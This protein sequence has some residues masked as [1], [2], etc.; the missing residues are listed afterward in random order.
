MRSVHG[1]AYPRRVRPLTIVADVLLVV[2]FAAGMTGL[3][4]VSVPLALCVGGALLLVAGAFLTIADVR[5]QRLAARAKQI[6]DAE[7]GGDRA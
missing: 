3:T 1:R 7:L 5:E 6:R 4:L 2:G